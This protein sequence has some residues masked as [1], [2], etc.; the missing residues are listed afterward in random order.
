MLIKLIKNT[1][2]YPKSPNIIRE[3]F[4]LIKITLRRRELCVLRVSVSCVVYESMYV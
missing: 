2:P 1:F 3:L 4:P